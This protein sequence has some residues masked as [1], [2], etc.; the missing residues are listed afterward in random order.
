[1]LAV[2]NSIAAQE[3]YS[4]ILI[5]KYIV[6]VVNKRIYCGRNRVD[7]DDCVPEGN[8]PCSVGRKDNRRFSHSEHIIVWH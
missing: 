6:T 5:G 8:S 7:F 3:T 1:M 2:L 4:R